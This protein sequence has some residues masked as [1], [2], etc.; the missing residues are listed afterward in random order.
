MDFILPVEHKDRSSYE[1]IVLKYGILI[2]GGISKAQNVQHGFS[3]LFY[4][5]AQLPG[6]WRRIFPFGFLYLFFRH[7]SLLELLIK[8]QRFSQLVLRSM[9]KRRCLHDNLPSDLKKKELQ[10]LYFS[11]FSINNCSGQLSLSFLRYIEAGTASP[12]VMNMGSLDFSPIVTFLLGATYRIFRMVNAA[13]PD[14]A[15]SLLFIINR[16]DSP[17]LY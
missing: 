10:L 14:A 11:Y 12:W 2:P 4:L 3:S 16:D 6:S 9:W 13:W 15:L 5:E 8:L 1:N 7:W 17:I